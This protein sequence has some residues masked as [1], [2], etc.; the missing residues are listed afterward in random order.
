MSSNSLNVIALISGGKD[1]LFSI[2]HCLESGHQVVALANLYPGATSVSNERRNASS[3]EISHGEGQSEEGED[4]N[5]FMYQTV[6]HSV[7]PLYEKCLGIPLYRR[8]IMGSAVQMGRYYDASD[9]GSTLDETEDL[10][11]LLREVMQIHPEAN[12]LCSGAILSTYQRTRVESVAVRLGLTPLAYLWQYPALPPPIGR[13]ESLTGLL[14]DMRAAGC[15]A[16]IIKIAS[17]G[18]KES[19]LWANVA[20][21]RTQLRLVNGLRPFFPDHEFWLR[22]AVLGEGGEYESLAVNGPRRLWRRRIV[23]PPEQQSTFTGEGGVSYLQLGK[24]RTEENHADG[25]ETQEESLRVP[26]LFDPQFQAVVVTVKPQETASVSSDAEKPDEADTQRSRRMLIPS[27][28][29]VKCLTSGHVSICNITSGGP[30]HAESPSSA[31]SQMQHICDDLK[32]LL[33]SISS[34]LDIATGL[35][36]SNIVSTTLLLKDM[37]NFGAVNP[38]YA[39]LFRSGEPNPPARVTIACPLPENIEVS[40]SVL[41]DAG[42]RDAR[43]GLHVQSRSYWAP[44]N[45]GPYSQAIC[46]PVGKQEETQINVHDAGLVEMVH[47]AGQIPLVPHSMNFLSQAGFLEETALGLQH[48]WRIGQERGVDMWPWGIAFLESGCTDGPVRPELSCR[49]WQQ[50]HLTGTRSTKAGMGEEGDEADEGPDA[51]DLQYNRASTYEASSG[52]MTVGQH[53]HLLPDA[54]IFRQDGSSATFVPPFVAAEVVSL[55]RS[56]PAEW[57]SMGIAN[58][59]KSPASKPRVSA[60]RKDRVWGSMAKVTIHPPSYGKSGTIVHL[61]TALVHQRADIAGVESDILNL[62]LPDNESETLSLGPAELVHGTAFITLQAQQEWSR[63]SGGHLL[64]NLAVI[65]CNSLFGSSGVVPSA[66]A[67]NN[68]AVS[69]LPAI[70]FGTDI[71][72]PAAFYP[73]LPLGLA[74]VMRIDQSTM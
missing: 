28:R 44:A 8:E 33:G 54:N 24:P 5:S 64:R 48:L 1:S 30:S 34:S 59:P 74:V 41:I 38:I 70:E 27:L 35:T 10:I 65:P 42:P 25:S 11:P 43:R 15:D 56:A 53:L 22:G 61:I 63:M 66:A 52:E 36:P 32:S 2:L 20:D 72:A 39:S 73:P 29:P 58:L 26:Q 7:I 19:L 62:I 51:W 4:L 60:V 47:M 55:P 31:A 18:I 17:G 6:G 71:Q 16:R 40:L 9:L 12:A 37:S 57:W 46:V 45:I 50:A 68:L 21:P 23:V 49:V 3:V 69:S 14:D 67:A 13:G